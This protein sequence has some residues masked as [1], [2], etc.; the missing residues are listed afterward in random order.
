MKGDVRKGLGRA[1]HSLAGPKTDT[2]VGA[3][4]TRRFAGRESPAASLQRGGGRIG[5]AG[6]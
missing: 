3:Y 5:K 4:P 2:P 1:L 6:D